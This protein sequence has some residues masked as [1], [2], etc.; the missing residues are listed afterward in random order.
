[1]WKLKHY[2]LSNFTDYINRLKFTWFSYLCCNGKQILSIRSDYF[3]HFWN[4]SR[5][6][7]KETDWHTVLFFSSEITLNRNRLFPFLF[8]YIRWIIALKG[9][10]AKIHLNEPIYGL[11]ISLSMVVDY[12]DSLIQFMKRRKFMTLYS[13]LTEL[14]DRPKHTNEN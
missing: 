5:K 10:R 2:L 8:D 1:M 13:G 9:E 11:L 14:I 12:I 3:V 6:I 4:L 7:R